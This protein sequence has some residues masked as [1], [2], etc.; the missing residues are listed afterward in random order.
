MTFIAP[1]SGDYVHA[2][3]NYERALNASNTEE[4][5]EE[6]LRVCLAGIARSAVGSGDIRKGIAQAMEMNDLA[7]LKQCASIL[8]ENKVCIRLNHD[9]VNLRTLS[10]TTWKR[11][12][13]LKW[14]E[15]MTKL[16]YCIPA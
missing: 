6:H 15:S 13:Y 1:I 4:N 3:V 2:L 7:L 14:L 10:R 5:Q 11:L 8:E 16:P 12:S 9:T